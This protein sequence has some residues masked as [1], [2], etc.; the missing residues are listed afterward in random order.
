MH[1]MKKYYYIFIVS[2]LFFSCKISSQELIPF[3]FNGKMGY[4]NQDLNIVIMPK[5]LK[6]DAFSAEG[7]AVVKTEVSSSAVIDKNGKE[8]IRLNSPVLMHLL[9]DAYSYYDS[10][11]KSIIRVKLK[12]VIIKNI[13][14][15]DIGSEG[16]IPVQFNSNKPSAGYIDLEGNKFFEDHS[17]RRTYKFVDGLATVILSDWYSAII[18]R[19]GNI[20][21]NLKFARLGNR[22]SEG[23]LFA[24]STDKKTGYI[25]KDGTFIISLP[26]LVSEDM[27]ASDFTNGYAIIKIGENPNFY[28][29]IDNKGNFISEKLMIDSISNFTE[30]FCQVAKIDQKLGIYKF[31][32]INNKGEYLI[33]PILDK[34]EDFCNGYARIILEGREGLLSQKGKI[35][36]SDDIMKSVKK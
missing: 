10:E 17:F 2:L 22:F 23:L 33:K 36:W 7:Y 21:G 1:K 12:Q 35:I 3:S 24:Q 13:K 9:E 31:G 18:D 16:L 27:T 11:G 6:T 26:I 4:L 34:A 25:D 20:I 8:I 29:I 32:F 5:Y 30:D 28:Q 14:N 19:K 15:T